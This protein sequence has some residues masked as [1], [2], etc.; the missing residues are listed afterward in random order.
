[1]IEVYFDIL[2]ESV[3]GYSSVEFRSDLGHGAMF[4]LM[5]RLIA[6][7]HAGLDEAKAAHAKRGKNWR[8]RITYPSLL[9]TD[10]GGYAAVRAAIG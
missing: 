3:P 4:V 9:A 10:L 5:A 6:F 8:E 2:S 7:L 1:M